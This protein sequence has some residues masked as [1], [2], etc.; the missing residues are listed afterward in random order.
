MKPKRQCSLALFYPNNV[1]GTSRGRW[2]QGGTGD[3]QTK[4]KTTPKTGETTTCDPG[5]NQTGLSDDEDSVP[6]GKDEMVI[7]TPTKVEVT[8]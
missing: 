7:D 6:E 1:R 3:Y 4:D 5:R 2:G 8:S